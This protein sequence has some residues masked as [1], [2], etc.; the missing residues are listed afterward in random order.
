MEKCSRSVGRHEIPVAGYSMV[1]LIGAGDGGDGCC[2]VWQDSSE[3]NSVCLPW[4]FVQVES[5][6]D[7]VLDVLVHK[8][9]H[10]SGFVSLRGLP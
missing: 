3:S 9:I 1:D 7:C 2:K 8:L 5:V 6:L 10:S 4:D